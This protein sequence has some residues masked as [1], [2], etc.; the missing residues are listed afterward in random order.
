MGTQRRTG[1]SY[2]RF[3]KGKQE[4]GD[5][6]RRQQEAYRD[7]CQRHNLTPLRAAEYM[8]RG[9]SGYR[10][11]H[12]KK[13]RLGELI[14]E[15]KAGTFEPGSVI[16]I[17]AWDRLGRLRPD[18]QTDLVAELLRTGVD[19]GVCQLNDVFTESDFGTH[20]WVTLSVFIMLA[21]QESV[22][23]GKRVGAAWQEKRRRAQAGECQKATETM[24]NGRKA[25][26]RRLPA[27]VEMAPNGRLRLIR[28]RAAVVKRIYRMA[29]EGL[30]L[31]RT[32]AALAKPLKDGGAVPFGCSGRWRK[33]YVSV[34]LNDRRAVGELQLMTGGKPDGPPLKNYYPPCVSEE[35]FDLARAG[36]EQRTGKDRL[37]RAEGPH[38]AK[39]ANVFKGLIIH[40]RDGSGMTI[41][42]RD[43][44]VKPHLVL[45]NVAGEQGQGRWWTF[46]YPAFEEGVLGLLK[47]VD[48]ADV[49][50]GAQEG[51]TRAD[52]V[53]ARLVNV[54]TDLAAIKDDLHR[55][56]SRH[57]AEV[58][59]DKEAEEER[60]AG[61]LQDELAKAARPSDRAWQELPGLLEQV[62]EGGDEARLR[63]APVLRR[64]IREMRVLIVRRASWALAAVQVFFADSDQRRDYLIVAR[65]AVN[66]RKGRWWAHSLADVVRPGELDLR[67]KSHSERLEKALAAVDLAGIV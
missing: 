5:S 1:I 49:L 30:G 23:K 19:I 27:W 22:Q 4:L 12:R 38:Q 21:Y 61:E 34:I 8:D 35:E 66:G 13:G 50:P 14:K 51:P 6:E 36:L 44:K 29:A 3:S 20:K 41:H 47:E 57:L 18:K 25:L 58:L 31:K 9:R 65:P 17:E 16:V 15:A 64:V 28:E 59:R 10:D 54:R 42:N 11:E 63:L 26:T 55:R 48:P 62:K 32:V 37:G 60:L 52:V 45:V 7:F 33:G 56:Y 53:R 40:A 46:P 67:Q 43:T 39:Y 2:G 24:G